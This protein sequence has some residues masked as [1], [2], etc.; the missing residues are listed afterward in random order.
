MLS[1]RQIKPLVLL[2]TMKIGIVNIKREL[3]TALGM[4][5]IVET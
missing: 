3:L 1:F 5:K 2:N 4:S